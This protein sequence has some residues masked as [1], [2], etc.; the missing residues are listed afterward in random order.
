MTYDVLGRVTNRIRPLGQLE[1]F[2]YDAN[3]N[4]ISHTD[5]NGQTTTFAYD[6]NNRLTARHFR[7]ELIVTYAYTLGRTSHYKP[8]AIPSLMT[9]RGRL[10]TSKKASG[11]VLIYTYDAAGNRTSVTTPQGTTSY[12]YDA[13][14]RLATGG[15][16][17][18]DDY[19]CLRR[20]G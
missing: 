20:C 12:T 5:F 7:R 2:A 10:L 17:H 9:A 4:Q 16:C 1:T 6:S 18:R 3:G 11:D 14:N 8:E 13:L 15:Q 19:L